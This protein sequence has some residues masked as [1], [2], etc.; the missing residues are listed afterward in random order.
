MTDVLIAGGGASGLM[1][2]VWSARLGFECA[3]IEKKDRCGIKLSITG[4][5]SVGLPEAS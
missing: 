5:L 4:R 3:V 1:C 2:A